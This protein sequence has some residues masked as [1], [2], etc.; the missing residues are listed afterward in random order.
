MSGAILHG[1]GRGTLLIYASFD[2]IRNFSKAH[3]NN[4]LLTSR[5]HIT[6]FFRLLAL[7]ILRNDFVKV[8]VKQSR[9]R[10]GV[11]QRVPGS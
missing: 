4:V 6:G 5:C 3:F 11:A 1:M 2:C 10:P 8:Q 7:A 9:Y